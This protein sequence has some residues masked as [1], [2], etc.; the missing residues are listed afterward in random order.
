MKMSASMD[1]RS[2]KSSHFGAIGRLLARLQYSRDCDSAFRKYI[3]RH[4][5]ATVARG[6]LY[7]TFKIT[8][9]GAISVGRHVHVVGPK[10]NITFGKR[11]KIEAGVVVQGICQ[12]GLHFGDDVTLCEGT[13]IRPSGHWGGNLGYGLKLGNR[14]SIGAYSFVGCSGRIDIGDD[15]MIG[16]RIT[17][18]AENHAFADASRPMKEQ[19]VTNKGITI[20]NDVWIG[21]CVTIL[22]GVTIADHSII[23]AGSVVTRD[24]PPYAI[25]AGVPARP[26]KSRLSKATP[27]EP[28]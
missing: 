1:N 3:W 19:G 7:R 25:V 17:L 11:C 10:F 15:V 20:G 13:M 16:P 8:S 28:A 21:A 22:D 9:D 12:A 14:S 26:L 2:E 4:L 27:N 6:V 23:A 18:I 24:V 5:F